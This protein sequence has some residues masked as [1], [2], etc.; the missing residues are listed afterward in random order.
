[1]RCGRLRA[2]GRAWLAEAWLLAEALVALSVYT[3]LPLLWFRVAGA[4]DAV[5][6]LLAFVTA[7]LGYGVTATLALVL[8]RTLDERRRHLLAER[9]LAEGD[10]NLPE[11]LMVW[12]TVALVLVLGIW[13]VLAPEP[14]PP[15]PR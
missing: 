13:F 2:I 7:L 3:A 6:R 12:Q 9:G 8:L 4:L 1:V 5:A 11:R 10:Y 15:F 14:K